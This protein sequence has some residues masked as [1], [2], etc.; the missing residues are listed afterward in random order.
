MCL[1]DCTRNA[2]GDISCE[3]I[4]QHTSA[5][6]S[7][8]IETTRSMTVHGSIATLRKMAKLAAVAFAVLS[9]ASAVCPAFAQPAAFTTQPVTP[10]SESAAPAESTPVVPERPKKGKFVASLGVSMPF[11][12]YAR[13]AGAASVKHF[14][15]DERTSLAESLAVG[16]IVNPKVTVF[17]SALFV[18]TLRTDQET[19]KTG[20]FFG[21]VAALVSYR[22]YKTMSFSAGP[23]FVY[24]EYFLDEMDFGALFVLAY[25]VPLSSNFSLAF[26]INSPQAYINKPIAAVAAGV[27]LGRRF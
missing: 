4:Q 3:V 8:A 25:G 18:E 15:P 10:A 5:I 12:I 16:Y 6:V 14:T 13:P 2:R 20:F 21:A 23:M 11:Y 1:R 7:D 26:T 19:A 22:F 24:R 17:V 27:N 9:A